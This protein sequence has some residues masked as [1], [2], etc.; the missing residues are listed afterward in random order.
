MGEPGMKQGSERRNVRMATDHAAVLL[1]IKSARL[2]TVRQV[3]AA[4]PTRQ[5]LPDKQKE[6]FS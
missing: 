4:M 3:A 1:Y 2:K 6:M 5:H